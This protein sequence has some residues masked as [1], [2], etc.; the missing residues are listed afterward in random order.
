VSV[1]NAIV[2]KFR[3]V[4]AVPAR[5][6]LTSQKAVGKKPCL[7]RSPL[8]DSLKPL[9]PK[10]GALLGLS[11]AW[12]RLKLHPLAMASMLLCGKLERVGHRNDVTACWILSGSCID[13]H[14]RLCQPGPG[15]GAE[16]LSGP[17]LKPV[18]YSMP[19]EKNPAMGGWPS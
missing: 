8:A 18:A 11:T 1:E 10:P 3:F 9:T 15:S 19:V 4:R 17:D 6:R 7:Q 5:S 2:I 14:T 13:A 16:K 12:S